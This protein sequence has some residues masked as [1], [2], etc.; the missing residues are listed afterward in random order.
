MSNL[1]DGGRPRPTG[2]NTEILTEHR[3]VQKEMQAA[4][5]ALKEARKARTAAVREHKDKMAAF[6]KLAQMFNDLSMEAEVRKLPG[7]Q[8]DNP[9]P[10]L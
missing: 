10:D 1:T 2:T 7:F 9:N 4:F 6:E 5:E 8:A 3:L